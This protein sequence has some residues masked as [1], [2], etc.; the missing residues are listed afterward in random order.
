MTKRSL[1]LLACGV[2]TLALVGVG[3]G[4]AAPTALAHGGKGRALRCAVRHHL[5]ADLLKAA[6]AYIGISV[7]QLSQQLPGH[8]LAQVAVNHGKTSAG[9]QTALVAAYQA[10]LNKLVAKQRI[11]QQRATTLLTRFQ[12]NVG[13]LVNRVFGEQVNRGAHCG[14][15]LRLAAFV[16]RTT[17]AYLNIS[18]GQLRQE[19]PGHS[20]AQ[21]AVNH[22]KTA[23]G[24]EAALVSA[25]TAKVNAAKT[26]G[27]LTDQQASALIARF[28]ARVGNIVNKV[29]P[30]K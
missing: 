19:L 18:V 14:A 21:I 20:L 10:D 17:A 24:L 9:L 15:G 30:S 6:A 4:V 27:K 1:R 26:A 16:L 13:T 23:S 29:F 11:T 8:S 2:A 22:G 3:T 7:G 25:F 5:R 28:Q 12:S